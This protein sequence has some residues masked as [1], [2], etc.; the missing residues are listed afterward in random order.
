MKTNEAGWDRGL[1][2]VF[3]LALLSLTFVGPQT[4]WGLAGIVL[5]ATGLWGSCPI[6]RLFGL[7]TC[8]VQPKDA[9]GLGAVR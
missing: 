6:Y 5:V 3:G 1:R 7:S 2:V 8:S 4:P 9:H